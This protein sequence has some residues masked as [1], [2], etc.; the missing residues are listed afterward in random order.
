MIQKS[1]AAKS[2]QNRLMF[3][4]SS[5]NFLQAYKRVSILKTICKLSKKTRHCNWRQNTAASK[6]K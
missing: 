2:L 3:L 5:E 1:Y 4:F 6:T